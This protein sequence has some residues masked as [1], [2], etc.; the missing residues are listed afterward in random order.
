MTTHEPTEQ[1]FRS[2]DRHR[3][4]FARVKGTTRNAVDQLLV[5]NVRDAYAPFRERFQQECWAGC[6]VHHYL[7]DLNSIK[8]HA[9]NGSKGIDLRAELMMKLRKDAEMSTAVLDAIDGITVSEAR[10]MLRLAEDYERILNRIRRAAYKAIG[11]DIDAAKALIQG[12]QQPEH[13][14]FAKEVINNR[15]KEAA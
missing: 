11:T 10:E 13:R 14:T 7:D 8:M 15:R 6:E 2:I 9:T 1:T 3:N 12:Y 5:G 4:N